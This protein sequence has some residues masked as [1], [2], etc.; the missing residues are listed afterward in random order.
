MFCNEPLERTPVHISR[1]AAIGI[2]NP[3]GPSE[4]S[5]D[6]LCSQADKLVATSTM[7]LVVEA[8]AGAAPFAAAVDV[9]LL[10]APEAAGDGASEPQPVPAEAA[11]SALQHYSAK[12]IVI[13]ADHPHPNQ[14]ADVNL[15]RLIYQR[16]GRA[17]RSDRSRHG[18]PKSKGS[19]SESC[20]ESPPQ[21]IG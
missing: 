12:E 7:R 20:R 8:D 6:L 5:P 19:L 21:G 1:P 3:W 11:R 17:K 9:E 10:H 2:D 18:K 13:G 16:T 15:A 14:L 4:P